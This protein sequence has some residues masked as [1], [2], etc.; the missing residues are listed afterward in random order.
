VRVRL[1]THQHRWLH[2]QI[3]TLL[4]QQKNS[5]LCQKSQQ[6]KC[7][8]DW[9]EP[10]VVLLLLRAVNDPFPSYFTKYSKNNSH[11]SR[12]TMFVNDEKDAKIG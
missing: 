8:V 11:C 6:D 5:Y 2:G 4:R 10:D 7:F 1:E 9:N 3:R 12:S